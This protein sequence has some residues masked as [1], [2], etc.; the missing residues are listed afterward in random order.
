MKPRQY[1]IRYLTP[2]IWRA[3]PRRKAEALQRFALI[4]KDSACQILGAVPLISDPEVKAGLFQHVLEEFHHA[5]LFEDTC[6]KF[7]SAH[8]NQPVITRDILVADTDGKP[9]DPEALKFFSYVHVGEREVNDDFSHYA[10]APLDK[11][12]TTVFKR[13]RADEAH[14]EKDSLELLRRFA[15]GNDRQVGSALFKSGWLRGWRAYANA[16]RAVGEVPLTIL[17]SGLYYIS[18][19]FLAPAFRG[20]LR[21]GKTDQIELLRRQQADSEKACREAAGRTT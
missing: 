18:G 5:D 10:R 2:W 1:V 12:I 6:R 16:M 17:L 4:E 14:H 21:M 7:S 19:L 20:R 15:G 13:V 3:H 8:L 9:S 11:E